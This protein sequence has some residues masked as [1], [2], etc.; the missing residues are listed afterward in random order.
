MLKSF[1][2]KNWAITTA[3]LIFV[4]YLIAGFGRNNSCI[5]L[6]SIVHNNAYVPIFFLILQLFLWRKRKDKITTNKAVTCLGLLII[7]G[8]LLSDSYLKL[9]ET[10]GLFFNLVTVIAGATLLLQILFWF[11]TF[12]RKVLIKTPPLR[13]K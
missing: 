13:K 2:R 11:L 9:G 3:Y 7:N 8:Y 4:V 1:F 6:S 5:K 12:V 10:I